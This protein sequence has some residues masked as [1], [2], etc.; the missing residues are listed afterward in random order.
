MGNKKTSFIFFDLFG[1]RP[2]LYY[3][4]NFKRISWAGKI[5]TLLYIII[6]I[7]FFIYK[8][9]RMVKK[10]DVIFYETSTFTGET[11]FIKLD[12]EIFYGG[13]AL[14]DPKT[15]QTFIDERIYYPLAQFITGKKEG[16]IWNF[17]Y[18]PLSIERCNLQKFGSNYRELFKDKNL[19][20]LYCLSEMNVVLEGHITYDVYSYFLIQFFPCVNSS[21][22]NYSCKSREEIESHLN[23]SMVTIKIQDIE[24]TPENYDKPTK[25][26]AKEV[27]SSV[28]KNLYQNINSYFHII[29]VETDHDVLGFEL[30]SDIKKKK[31]FKYDETFILP[32]I[33]ENDIFQTGEALCDI[34]MQL[35]E[36]IITLKRTKAKL[37]DILEDVGGFMTVILSIFRILSSFIS[38][39]LYEISIINNLFEF[40]IDKKTFSLK[41]K[42]N[43]KEKIEKKEIKNF[44]QPIKGIKIYST[45]NPYHKISLQS[46]NNNEEK[47]YNKSSIQTKNKFNE[48]GFNKNKLNK[49]ILL[50]NK[51]IRIKKKL[52]EPK[53]KNDEENNNSKNYLPLNDNNNINYLI[54]QGKEKKN[55]DNNIKN[56]VNKIH[57]NK[58]CIFFCFLCARKRKNMQNT[59][60][61]EGMRI[62][63]ENLDILNLFRKLFKAEKIQ[64]EFIDKDET[65]KMS[66][67][68]KK[69]IQDIYIS[70]YGI[71]ASFG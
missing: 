22:N 55:E 41:N 25:N 60:I 21:S 61:D 24:L 54:N 13:F 39:S 37:I 65:I 20:N 29:N 6:Y 49:D 68:C 57:L 45:I 23:K 67:K 26:R 16:N 38:R 17:K 53:N 27:S 7:T 30:F 9:V 3:K 47:E 44:H 14:A 71:Y 32:S 42:N 19:D 15:L 12:N 70:L 63:R 40:D 52:T 58:F 1:K 34:T 50:T 48:D 35:S 31:Y 5:L 28:F 36:E 8:L 64:D 2:D 33:K 18:N 10:F 62:V 56:I 4:G 66:D 69:N 59:L 46:I 51:E 11:P 43:Y